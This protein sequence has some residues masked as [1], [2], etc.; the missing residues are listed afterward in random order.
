MGLSDSEFLMGVSG[1]AMLVHELLDKFV[2]QQS[3][4]II[5]MAQFIESLELVQQICQALRIKYAVFTG[6]QRQNEKHDELEE[7][8]TD[9]DVLVLLCTSKTAAL[10]LNLQAATAIILLD[11][12]YNPFNDKQPEARV[13]RLGQ[14][15]PSFA[16]YT[17]AIDSVEEAVEDIIRKKCILPSYCNSQ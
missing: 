9:P 1:K 5:I 8:T 12:D 15:K 16:V 10:G 17:A 4:K 3:R 14:A 7:F 6:I 13:H 2:S 11:S